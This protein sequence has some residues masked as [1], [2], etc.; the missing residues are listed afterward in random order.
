[1]KTGGRTSVRLVELVDLF[2]TLSDLAGL[3]SPPGLEGRSFRP[4]LADP[5]RPWKTA[6][7][8]VVSRG[9]LLGRTVRT[10]HHRYTEWDGG[11]QGV[12]LYDHR[13]DPAEI[14]NLA[15]DAKNAATRLSLH[16]L[17]PGSTTSKK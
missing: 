3:R 13:H 10:E 15:G 16:A 5:G 12:E 2:P 11:R 1:M 17:L 14:H 6:A 8:S 7:R 4:L 9:T